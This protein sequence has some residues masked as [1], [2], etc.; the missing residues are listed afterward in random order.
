MGRDR[1]AGG[2]VWVRTNAHQNRVGG[3]RRARWAGEL[4]VS[5]ANFVLWTA[6]G[7]DLI[8]WLLR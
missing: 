6:G 5:T 2:V 7:D 8:G 3:E 4:N 1:T